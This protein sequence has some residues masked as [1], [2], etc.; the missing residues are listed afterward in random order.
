[1]SSKP[2]ALKSVPCAKRIGKPQ[3]KKGKTNTTAKAKASESKTTKE[4]CKESN[5]MSYVTVSAVSNKETEEASV[6]KQYAGKLYRPTDMETSW[7]TIV[8]QDGKSRV[9]KSG[10]QLQCLEVVA[11]YVERNPSV[12]AEVYIASGIKLIGYDD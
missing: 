5:V 2:C 9:L 1:M 3:A 10:T 7:F 12:S 4:P 6:T 8:K 11:D